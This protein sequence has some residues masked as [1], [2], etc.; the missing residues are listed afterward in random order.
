M[1]IPNV[2]LLNGQDINSDQKTIKGWDFAILP[3]FVY[4][5][6]RGIQFGGL[7]SI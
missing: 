3:S 2:T 6:D 7:A 1:S 5:T 4:H